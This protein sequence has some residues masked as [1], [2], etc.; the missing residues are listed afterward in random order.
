M[1]NARK[2]LENLKYWNVRTDPFGVMSIVSKRTNEIIF[3]QDF[4][5]DYMIDDNMTV[6]QA[7]KEFLNWL[8]EKPSIN[9]NK[10]Y[11]LKKYIVQFTLDGIFNWRIKINKV[12]GGSVK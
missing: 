3:I 2:E 7:R 11:E 12:F 5:F 6:E 1:N 9:S 8:K 4:V 10:Y